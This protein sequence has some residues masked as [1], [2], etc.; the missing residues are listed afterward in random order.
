MVA[1][2]S[3]VSDTTCGLLIRNGELKMP[4]AVCWRA[5]GRLWANPCA[6]SARPLGSWRNEAE[7]SHKGTLRG[8]APSMIGPW[9]SVARL[10]E[11]THRLVMASVAISV[12]Q[13]ALLVPIA[14]I[15]RRIFD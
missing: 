10:L 3:R 2:L 13:S 14:F 9:R 6:S 4:P 5:I 7:W 12:A 15:V 1:S 8:R 11:G